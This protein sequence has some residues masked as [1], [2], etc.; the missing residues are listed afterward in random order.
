MIVNLFERGYLDMKQR[1]QSAFIVVLAVVVTFASLCIPIASSAIDNNAEYV[2]TTLFTTINTTTTIK[3]DKSNTKRNP[4]TGSCGVQ[5]SW[6]VDFET[7]TLTISGIGEMSIYS[8]SSASPW[9]SYLS[10]IKSVVIEDGVKT[11]GDYAFYDI[12]NIATIMLPN[13]ITSIGDYAFYNCYDL[14]SVYYPG[15][16]EEWNKVSVGLNNNALINN[17]V[18]E[19]NSARPVYIGGSCG[20][21]ITYVLYTD[22]ELS[23]S[24]NGN[25]DDFENYYSVPWYKKSEKIKKVIIGDNVT[26][27]GKNAFKYCRG[28]V[29]VTISDSV[30]SIGDYAFEGCSNLVNVVIGNNITAI[31]RFA[32]YDCRKLKSI[33]IGSNLET[34]N[35]AAFGGCVNL[36]NVVI[37][38]GVTT[39]GNYAFMCC[40]R[41]N[42][43]VIPKSVVT[44]S[45]FAFDG[46][47]GLS[48]VYYSGTEADWHNI[49]FGYN[50]KNLLSATIY[51][52]AT[53]KDIPDEETTTKWNDL[54]TVGFTRPTEV[55]TTA[56][57]TTIIN[58]TTTGEPD[59]EYTTVVRPERPTTTKSPET[60]TR[61]SPTTKVVQKN[62]T[63]IQIAY[64]STTIINYGDTII[65]HAQV[66][67]RAENT[68]V[69]WSVVGDGVVINPSDDG[70]SC[71]VT[72]VSNGSVIV[73][74]KVVDENGK[75]CTDANGYEISDSR[76]L[77]SIG[78]FLQKIISFFKNLFGIS[79]IILQAK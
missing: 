59:W 53:L 67:D 23:I 38:E 35:Y 25:M 63:N 49:T 54:T 68:S 66:R 18:V 19:S 13:S 3:T 7:N 70:L 28:I 31:G 9:Y 14:N 10:S 61:I 52:D 47:N 5:L 6:I 72:S 29:N 76:Q 1:S 32:F 4:A 57:S 74:A 51:F 43:I 46:C 69:E 65:L 62:K 37:P 60:T 20:E 27:I 78:S 15:T 64:S 12:S 33:N 40:Y 41:L 48:S 50:N 11:V 73:M 42:N 45:S 8:S 56:L 24:G 17:L 21:N 2:S 58:E 71:R 55:N 75:V 16:F 30:K 34:I 77:T 79:R 26:Y 39:I 44:I 36:A 22:G